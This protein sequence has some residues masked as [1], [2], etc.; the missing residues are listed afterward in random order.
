MSDEIDI[1]EIPEVL[2]YMDAR[3]RL[4]TFRLTHA[5]VMEEYAGL[6]DQYNTTLQ[7]ADKAVRERRV[8][9]GPFV[10]KHFATK[11]DGEALFNSVGRDLFLQLGGTIE[12]VPS[13]NV[14]RGKL[15]A[16][17]AQ[18][19]VKPEV[20]AVVRQETPNFSKPPKVVIP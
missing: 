15:E 17:I 7:A 16:A 19:R 14:D 4:E 8:S 6:C 1:T 9:C 11:Y 5:K 10:L 12:Q 2:D 20:V 13:Y 18:N 3:E